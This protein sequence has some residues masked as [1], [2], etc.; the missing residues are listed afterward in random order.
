MLSEGRCVMGEILH[1]EGK[2]LN[3]EF[4]EGVA[5]NFINSIGVKKFFLLSSNMPICLG[6]S[7][8]LREM[9]E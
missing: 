8:D 6:L 4:G 3:A 7:N 9:G 5:V 1:I 2:I